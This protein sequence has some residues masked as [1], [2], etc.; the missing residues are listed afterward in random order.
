MGSI[1]TCVQ[2]LLGNGRLRRLRPRRE[3]SSQVELRDSLAES[4]RTGESVEYLDVALPSPVV[5][6]KAL[7]LK[8]QIPSGIEGDGFTG[9]WKVN[10]LRKVGTH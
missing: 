1:G 8:V 9:T 3:Q 4:D 2:K 6:L 10:L 7:V 5:S